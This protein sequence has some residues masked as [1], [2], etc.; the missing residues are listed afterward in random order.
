MAWPCATDGRMEEAAPCESPCCT[1][2][3][4]RS[5]ARA[6]RRPPQRQQ[7]ARAAARA[8][9]LRA[10]APP[11]C[12]ATH[13]SQRRAHVA[14]RDG[15]PRLRAPCAPVRHASAA[16]PVR[17]VRR[18]ATLPA[19]DGRGATCTAG[20]ALLRRRRRRRLEARRDVERTAEPL[21]QLAVAAVRGEAVEPPAGCVNDPVAMRLR[22]RLHAEE[23]VALL[24]VEATQRA[25]VLRCRRWLLQRSGAHGANR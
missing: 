7:L 15:A 14:S 4:R 2:A 9:R 20:F 22:G 25:C 19:G 11:A 21:G 13:P 23:H 18:P 12:C 16:A 6:P 3:G 24:L 1:R 17:R 8:Q 10:C 5:R